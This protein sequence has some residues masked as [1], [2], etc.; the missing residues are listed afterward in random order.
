MGRINALIIVLIAAVLTAGCGQTPRP[1]PVADQAVK[2]VVAGSGTNLPVTR[3]LAK[4]YAASSGQTITVPGSIGSGG[5]INAVTAGELALGLISRPLTAAEKAKGLKELPYARVAVVFA[6]HSAVPDASVSAADVLAILAGTKK[7]WADGTRIYVLLREKSDSAN[8][9]LGNLMPGYKEA[10]FEAYQEDR[11]QVI[12]TD[13][14]EA[15]A[16]RRTPGAFGVTDSTWILAAA[17]GIK[18]L[19]FE[20]V[21]P[22]IENVA[23]GR[24]IFAKDLAFVYKGELD[25]STADFVN[26]AFSPAGQAAIARTGALP[27]GR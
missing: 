23:N 17:G 21:A 16:I 1:Q 24:Y 25:K 27:L 4:D 15:E 3:E 10:L 14:D 6:A 26:F 12:Y 20:G 18:P 2:T 5:T 19:A 8:L 22:S 9:V 11:W 13:P 7:S